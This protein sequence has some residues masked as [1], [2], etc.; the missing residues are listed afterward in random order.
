MQEQSTQQIFGDMQSPDKRNK[1]GLVCRLQ[2]GSCKLSEWRTCSAESHLF[3]VSFIMMV[4]RVEKTM[5]DILSMGLQKHARLTFGE[6]HLRS[7]DGQSGFYLMNFS[8]SC[9]TKE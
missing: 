3:S 9:F 2:R 7:S 6:K 5:K 8:A 1:R 4:P